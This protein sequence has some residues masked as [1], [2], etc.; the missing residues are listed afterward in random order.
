MNE[1]ELLLNADAG[2]D[3]KRYYQKYLDLQWKGYII[4]QLGH[5]FLTDSGKQRLIELRKEQEEE[6]I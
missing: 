2:N 1:Y 3:C 5:A 6:A 4:W